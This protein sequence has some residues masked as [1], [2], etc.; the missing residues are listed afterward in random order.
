LPPWPAK[1]GGWLC[2][3]QLTCDFSTVLFGEVF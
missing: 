3:Q 1:G 2:P